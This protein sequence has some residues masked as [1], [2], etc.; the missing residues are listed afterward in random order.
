[1]NWDAFQKQFIPLPNLDMALDTSRVRFTNDFLQSFQPKIMK[2]LEDMECLEAGAIANPDEHRQVGHYW[3]RNFSLAPTTTIYDE[4]KQNWEQLHTFI[5]SVLQDRPFT[6][7]L[8]IGI[9]GS[10]LGPQLLTD[11]LE[12]KNKGLSAVF[13][14]NTD[15]DGIQRT[16]NR[17]QERLDKTLVLV[18]SKSGSTAEPRNALMEAQARFRSLHLDFAHQAIAITCPGSQLD[19]TAQKEQWLARFP[20]WDWV[21]GRT[22][23]CS[24]VGL[25]PAGLCGIDIDELVEGAAEMDRLTR[26]DS[27]MHN[28]ALLLALA[29]Y[30]CSGGHGQRNMVVLPYKDALVLFPRYLQ[31]LIMESLGK[32]LTMDGQ[33]V[34]QGLTVYGNKGSTD[35]HAYIQ[36]LRDGLRDAFVTFI[37]VQRP[38]HPSKV[39]VEK[40][41]TSNDF[42]EGFLL[43]TRDALTEVHCPSITITLQQLDAKSLGALIALFERTVGFYA[44]FIHI[45]AYH[46]PGVE[47]GKKAARVYLEQQQAILMYLQKHPTVSFTAEQLAHELQLDD[48]TE[49]VFKLLEYL[50]ANQRIRCERHPLI[51]HNQYSTL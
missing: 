50:T 49:D 6:H 21:G 3:L 18:T 48:R 32:R 11:A 13:I 42:L 44:N 38:Y 15:P 47:A 37:E 16:L 29:W 25:L 27:V 23:W 39:L 22:S 26:S 45:N 51:A 30:I 20:L 5:H 2:A 31:Q 33:E 9:G 12:P 10:A 19:K 41:F 1:M 28:P 17:L 43:G 14:D 40:T 7:L 8:C 35:Q 4:L 36:Q 34:N 24:N 46:Q